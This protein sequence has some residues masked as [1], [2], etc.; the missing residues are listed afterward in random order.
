MATPADWAPGY[1]RQARADLNTFDALQPPS[2][3]DCHKLLFLQ[4]AS[5]KLVKAHLCN[6]GSDPATLQGSHAYV[7]GTLPR[8]LHNELAF[9]NSKKKHA[10]EVL[11][12][13][14]HLARE[15]EVLAPAVRGR[16]GQRPDNC[17][18][19]WVDWQG[20]L[21]VPLDWSFSPTQLLLT[22]AGVTFLKLVSSA[23][24]RLLQ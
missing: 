8:V 9:F 10:R 5:E 1:A 24:N 21:H 6:S 22:P 20:K 7:E 11:K 12:Q 15:I 4:M 14:K 16:D 19:P 3:P 2:V 13:A 18:Y 17:E 23:V